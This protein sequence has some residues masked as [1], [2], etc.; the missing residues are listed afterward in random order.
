MI[1][2]QAM[3]QEPLAIEHIFAL[4]ICQ[5][6]TILKFT[7]IK[8]FFLHAHACIYPYTQ[9]FMFL[10]AQ[11]TSGMNHEKLVKIFV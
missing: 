4:S 6:H 1:N 11:N 10:Y 2:Q 7:T 3:F 9:T 8:H 5:Q